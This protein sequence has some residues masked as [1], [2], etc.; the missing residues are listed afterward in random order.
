MLWRNLMRV[1]H[2]FYALVI[3]NNSL[4]VTQSSCFVDHKCFTCVIPLWAHE[5][6]IHF[7]CPI[8]NPKESVR[9][10]FPNKVCLNISLHVSGICCSIL[11]RNVVQALKIPCHRGEPII[12]KFLAIIIQCPEASHN[13][14]QLWAY[15][16]IQK[17]IN[18]FQG[19]YSGVR[20][21]ISIFAKRELDCNLRSNNFNPLVLLARWPHPI[22]LLLELVYQQSLTTYKYGQ[23]R[24]PIENLL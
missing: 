1:G 15:W 23:W 20:P 19:S 13:P 14:F 5:W 7:P 9:S 22:W 21:L 16:S 10:R 6:K 8:Y 2:V 11:G 24:N 3:L 17:K 4:S 12:A 18:Y